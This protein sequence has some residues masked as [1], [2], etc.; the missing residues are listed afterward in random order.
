[1]LANAARV[2]REEGKASEETD[3][4]PAAEEILN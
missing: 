3:T 4:A 2:M 1:M